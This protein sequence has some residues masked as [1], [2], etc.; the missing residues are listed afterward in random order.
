ME[1]NGISTEEYKINLMAIVYVHSHDYS[2]DFN[3][4]ILMLKLIKWYT[5]SMYNLVYANYTLIKAVNILLFYFN[6][7]IIL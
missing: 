4:Y 6:P 5:L 1:Q 3:S 7:T 2:D